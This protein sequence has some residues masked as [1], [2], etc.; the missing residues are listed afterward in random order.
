MECRQKSLH[1]KFWHILT[2]TGFFPSEVISGKHAF[3]NLYSL[4]FLLRQVRLNSV[5]IHVSTMCQGLCQVSGNTGLNK[6]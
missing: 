2:G 6:Y 1:D 4:K 3:E 5:S